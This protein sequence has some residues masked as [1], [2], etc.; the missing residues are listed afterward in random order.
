MI[1]SDGRKYIGEF[2]DGE[3]HGKGTLIYPDGK[4]LTGEFNE[5]EFVGDQ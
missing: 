4:T 2:Q 1:Y 3:R 5:G